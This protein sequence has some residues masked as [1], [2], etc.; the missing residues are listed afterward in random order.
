MKPD[1]NIIH[2]D[3]IGSTNTYAIENIRG[4]PHNTVITADIQ[5][6]GRGRYKRAW[7]SDTAKNLYASFVVK[8]DIPYKQLP[9]VNFPQLFSV[10]TAEAFLSYGAQPQ[11]KWPNDVLL[12][13]KKCAGILSEA[14]F[15]GNIFNGVVVGVGVNIGDDP[16]S[17]LA[18]KQ[19][20]T[21]LSSEIKKNVE[22]SDFFSKML[23]L[24]ALMC[25]SFC[26]IGFTSIKEAYMRYFSHTGKEISIEN[27]NQR[28]SGRVSGVSDSGELILKTA[29]GVENI[30]IGEVLWETS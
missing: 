30:M 20:A 13:G 14:S 7:T 18:V 2:F 15:D 10:I 11:I 9:L 8:P 24:Y 4:L 26:S 16:S 22:K 23:E 19:P 6:N 17:R 25:D 29:S 12:N 27:A 21:A 28:L 3:T 1:F 5:T